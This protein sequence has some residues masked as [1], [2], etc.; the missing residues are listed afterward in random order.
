MAK[1]GR[2]SGSP[3]LES[4]RTK[5]QR[6]LMEEDW[7]IADFPAPEGALWTIRC[8]NAI[9]NV[10]FII[11]STRIPDRLD[12]QTSVGVSEDHQNLIAAMPANERA[13]LWWDLRFEL[14][15]M[16]LEFAGFAEPVK[17]ITLTQKIYNDGLTR[18][19]FIQR[20]NQVKAGILLI[21]WTINRRSNQPPDPLDADFVN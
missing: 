8:T 20:I 1:H 3:Q 7:Q 19:R 2:S 15:K 6:W 12:I 21:I 11:Q 14:L 9:G 18:D 4:K 10:L 17:E 16:K 5:V 13:S